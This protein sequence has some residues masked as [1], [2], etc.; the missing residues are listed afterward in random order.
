MNTYYLKVLSSEHLNAHDGENEP[1]DET[2]EEYVED[3]GDGLDERVHDH[4]CI[5]W[6]RSSINLPFS[7]GPNLLHEC[8]AHASTAYS[9]FY[10]FVSEK[11]MHAL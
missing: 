7:D 9:R 6:T 10:L 5:S 3:T 11:E 2:D 1:K 4:L 8:N